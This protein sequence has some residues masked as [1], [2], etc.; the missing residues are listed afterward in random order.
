MTQKEFALLYAIKKN[1]VKQYRALKEASGVSLGY[2][3]KAI[4]LFESN[5]WVDG[6]G[7]T[8]EGLVALQPYKVNAVIILTEESPVM[9]ILPNGDR[10]KGLYSVGGEIVVERL[11]EQIQDAG[12]ERVV[13]VLGRQ[14][15]AYFYLE[16]KYRGVKVI[17]NPAYVVKGDRNTLQLIREYIP[18]SYICLAENYFESNVFEEYVY[19]SFWMGRELPEGAEDWI[20]GV[21]AKG[22]ITKYNGREASKIFLL[23]FAYWDESFSGKIARLLSDKSLQLNQGQAVLRK[24][25][26]ENIN[27][28]GPIELRLLPA[29]E[30]GRS[31]AN[32]ITAEENSD[33]DAVYNLNRDIFDNIAKTICCDKKE[34]KDIHFIK[35][36]LTNTSFSFRVDGEKYVY[37]HPGEGTDAIISRKHEKKALELARSIGVDTTYIFMNDEQGWKI[38]RFVEGIRTPSYESFE[39]SKRVL[40]VLRRLHQKRL[41]V[42]WS[43]RPWEETCKIERLIKDIKGQIVDPAYEELKEVIKWCYNKCHNDGVEMCFCHCDTYAPNWMLAAEETI[44]IDW[45]Y[46]GFADPGCDIGTYIMDSLWEVP[47]AERF[48][49]EYCGEEYSEVLKFHYLAYTAI[50]SFYWYTWALYR[51]ACGSVMGESVYNWHLMAERYSKYLVEYFGD[52]DE[53]HESICV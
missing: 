50:L 38:S 51:E 30:S 6:D 21:D 32:A 44:L 7:I 26:V 20:V 37:R 48:I 40:G 2:I 28:L 16:K 49:K 29:E 46:A 52:E 14:K 18:N 33:Y 42:D 1:G 43:F 47:E 39:D 4:R 17:I 22:I 13:L 10:P 19:R 45:E 27:Y 31:N 25:F 12:I 9:N 36:G 41:F 11:I 53:A 35:E 24:L 34:I 3:S 15:E 8:A 5:G 23:G